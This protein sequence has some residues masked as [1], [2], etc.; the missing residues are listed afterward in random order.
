MYR[1]NQVSPLLPL[2]QLAAASRSAISR[3][4]S[5]AWSP[6]LRLTSSTLRSARRAP[7]AAAEAPGA[8]GSTWPPGTQA[9]QVTV[10][11]AGSQIASAPFESEIPHEAHFAE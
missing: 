2:P 1:A 8:P 4:T 3:A 11:A 5:A 7:S 10:L 6:Y 9:R